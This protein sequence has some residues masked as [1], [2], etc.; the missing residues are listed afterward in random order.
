MVL[1]GRERWQRREKGREK[2]EEEDRK[3][4]KKERKKKKKKGNKIFHFKKF[5]YNFYDKI[6]N[7]YTK[8]SFAKQDLGTDA[9]LIA[10]TL[11]HLSAAKATAKKI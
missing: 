1:T 11:F 5:S 6:L 8:N 10:I 7:E 4:K 9:R 2:G 3:E